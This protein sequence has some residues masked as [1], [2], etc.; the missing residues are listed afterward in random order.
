[1]RQ[2]YNSFQYWE[3]LIRENRT[4]RGQMFMNKIPTDKSYYIHTLIFGKENGLNNAWGY[5]PS[6]TALLGYI[7]YSFLQEAFYMWI[8]CKD[9]P[10]SYIPVIPVEDVIKQ[11]EKSKKI[12][13][14]EAAEM[15]KFIIEFDKCWSLPKNKIIPQIKRLAREFNRKWYGD[16]TEF[17]YIKIFETASEL[18]KFVVKS[19]FIT[20]DEEEFEK[21]IGVS[22]DEW[23]II[24][25]NCTKDSVLG[26]KFRVILQKKL[27]EII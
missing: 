23:E 26:E 24:Y 17:L 18:G 20:S 13:S 2:N 12:S 21:R 5:F 6:E 10:I 11:G 25:T 14:K 1:M 15:R 9:G 19:N 27:T 4:M 3:N 8:N 16:S 7:Q 22:I